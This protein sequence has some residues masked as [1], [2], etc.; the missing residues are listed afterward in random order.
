MVLHGAKREKQSWTAKRRQDEH[1]SVV[2][3]YAA[4]TTTV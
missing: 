2:E 3:K 4:A 1:Q